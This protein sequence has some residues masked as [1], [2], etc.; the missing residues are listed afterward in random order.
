M[1][2]TKDDKKVTLSTTAGSSVEILFYG[3]TV[4][5]WKASPNAEPARERLFVS[6]KAVLDG[7][8]PVRGGIPIAFP[9]F[10]PPSKPEHQKMGQH[11]FARSTVWKWDSV[12][13]DNETGVAVRLVL[14]PTPEIKEVFPHPFHLAYVVTLTAHQLSTDL[15]VTNTGNDPLT[16]QAL[17]HTYFEADAATCTVSPLKGLTY[18]DKVKNY[19]ESVETRDEVP[20]KEYTDAV[21][22]NSGGKYI[23]KWEGGGVEVKAVGFKDVVVWNPQAEAGSKIADLHEGACRARHLIGKPSPRE[24]VGSEA[25][26]SAPSAHWDVEY[27]L[28]KSSV[29]AAL[30]ARVPASRRTNAQ[31]SVW[32]AD[33][34]QEYHQHSADPRTPYDPN[35]SK[36]WLKNPEMLQ[37]LVPPS[38][39]EGIN[40]DGISK[41]LA[42]LAKNGYTVHTYD[43]MLSSRDLGPQISRK[44]RRRLMIERK[45]AIYEKAK[46]AHEASK[47]S[48]PSRRQP[49]TGPATTMTPKG[50]YSYQPSTAPD[51]Y[52][53]ETP[54]A[55][56]ESSVSV[57]Q[58]DPSKW[59]ESSFHEV[60]P[61]FLPDAGLPADLALM[62]ELNELF[63]HDEQ[64]A[65]GFVPKGYYSA[66]DECYQ[67][68]QY[69]AYPQQGHYSGN[70][71]APE[72]PHYPTTPGGSRNYRG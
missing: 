6:K 35:T 47:A 36:P 5:S 43:E 63:T 16:Y 50:A 56:R 38:E 15:H 11:G 53:S 20:V 57:Q 28:W 2:Y 34:P 46:S 13:M 71:A 31:E 61:A 40:S 17:L 45:K 54:V 60:D 44:E 24:Q 3:A 26:L 66:Q 8:K 65:Y 49:P 18:I 72:F 4:L 23:G 59:L 29:I 52:P 51:H 41:K 27:E 55:A 19:A 25:K 14:E 69:G 62:A 67:R 37:S 58:I 33:V 12:V 7:S 70:A 10:G 68:Q 30:N 42:W 22:K 1:P 48:R 39:R 32:Q 21:Y 9:F 64:V